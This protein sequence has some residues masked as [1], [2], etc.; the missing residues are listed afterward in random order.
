MNKVPVIEKIIDL[1]VYSRIHEVLFT[2]LKLA[3]FH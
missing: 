3:V 2:V 1:S